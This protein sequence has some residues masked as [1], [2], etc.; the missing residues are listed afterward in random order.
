MI[1]EELNEDLPDSEPNDAGSPLPPA[2]E[3]RTNIRI[4]TT[5]VKGHS[6]SLSSENKQLKLDELKNQ[7]KLEASRT[8]YICTEE[9]KIRKRLFEIDE[10]LKI[11]S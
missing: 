6:R 10:K 1:W 4:F 11:M 5:P 2:I 8:I 3:S 9:D 7:G